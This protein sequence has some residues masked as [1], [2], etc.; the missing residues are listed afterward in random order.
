M[1]CFCKFREIMYKKAWYKALENVVKEMLND[2]KK[3][4]ELYEKINYK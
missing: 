4:I 2:F 1:T 3:T